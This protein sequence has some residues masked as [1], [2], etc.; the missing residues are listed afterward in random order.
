[1]NYL[2]AI[3]KM[4]QAEYSALV[5]AIEIGR[6]PNGERLTEEQRQNA[7]SAVIAYGQLKLPE[8][9][10]VGYIH[11]PKHDHCGSDGDDDVQTLNWK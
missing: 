11:S 1:M 7:M 3:E 10:R 6:W 4:T 8:D 5:T 2:A 9:E